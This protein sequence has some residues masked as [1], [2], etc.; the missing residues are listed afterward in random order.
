MN[1]I[2]HI[3]YKVRS[4]SNKVYIGMTCKDLS[5][6]K[7]QHLKLA[8]SGSPCAIHKAILKY[9]D[10]LSWTILATVKSRQEA[11]KLEKLYI[12]KFN[13]LENGYNLTIGGDGVVGRRLTSAEKY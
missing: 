11:I 1:E 7:F 4:P 10:R 6:R 9:G 12:F 3:V 13:S 5:V 8:K 2:K